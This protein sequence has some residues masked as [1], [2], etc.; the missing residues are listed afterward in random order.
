MFITSR[1][2]VSP[3]STRGVQRLA[4]R[5]WCRQRARYRCRWGAVPQNSKAIDKLLQCGVTVILNV[6][7]GDQPLTWIS[8][9]GIFL[10][11]KS[12]I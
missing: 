8:F 11:E 6:E 9:S 5:L 7:M 1:D 4:G 10:L 3:R 2:L 12:Q